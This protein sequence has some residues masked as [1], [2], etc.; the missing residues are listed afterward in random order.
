M[1]VA[2]LDPGPEAPVDTRAL[3]VEVSFVRAQLKVLEADPSTVTVKLESSNP[4]PIHPGVR[5]TVDLGAIDTPGRYRVPVNVQALGGGDSG[6]TV[7]PDQVSVF[8]DDI[9]TRVM[10]VNFRAVRPPAP[11]FVMG[12]PVVDPDTVTITG[13]SSLIPGATIV[14]NIDLTHYTDDVDT[15]VPVSISGVDDSDKHLFTI[16]PSQIRVFIPIQHASDYDTVPVSPI[17][18]GV[19]APGIE[20]RRAVV[21]PPTITVSGEPIVIESLMMVRTAPISL[22]GMSKSF[23]VHVA[24]DPPTGVRLEGSQSVTVKVELSPTATLVPG[25]VHPTPS[26]KMPVPGPIVGAGT[27]KPQGSPAPARPR[28]GT[29]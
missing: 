6:V 27:L 2:G 12:T 13:P 17:V 16:R 25:P 24:L 7:V 11:G 3:Q 18:T 22:S 9:E 5:A 1:Y 20:F 15:E 21:V 28:A 10:P 14:A 4:L 26:A 23:S 8:L 19:P 29:K